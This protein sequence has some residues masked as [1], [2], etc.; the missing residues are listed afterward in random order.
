MYAVIR[1]GGKQYRVAPG[2]TVK[3]ET[4]PGKVGSKITFPDVLAV[5]T[6]EN[7]L[8]SGPA[9]SEATVVGKIVAQ[10]RHPKELVLKYRKTKQYKILRG[11][12]QNYTAVQVSEIKL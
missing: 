8:V 2:D 7:K 9:A 6:E 1:C 4:V 10:G 5:R 11:H 12:R 3:I